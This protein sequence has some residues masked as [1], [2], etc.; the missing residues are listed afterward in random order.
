[1]DPSLCWPTMD[2]ECLWHSHQ[3]LGLLAVLTQVQM[4]W[5]AVDMKEVV[6]VHPPDALLA[7]AAQVAP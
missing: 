1:M 6:V 2:H 7:L 3:H 5:V 4:N